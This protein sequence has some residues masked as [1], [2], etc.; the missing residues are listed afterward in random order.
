MDSTN[1]ISILGN[2]DVTFLLLKTYLSVDV[3]QQ[4]DIDDLLIDK[5]GVENINDLQPDYVYSLALKNLPEPHLNDLNILAAQKTSEALK[6]SMMP[7][8]SMFGNLGTSF[9]NR[10]LYINGVNLY[11]APIGKV[12]VGG[13]NYDVLPLQPFSTFIYGKPGLFKQYSNN[14]RQ[15]IGISINIPIL[16]SALLKTNYEKSKLYTKSLVI[17]KEQANEKLKHD[18]YQAFKI[19]QIAIQ[20]YNASR[21]MVEKAQRIYD[22]AVTK[23]NL[24]MLST[25]EFT[26]NLNNLYKAKMEE[27]VNK[28][29][30]IFKIKVLEFY[31]GEGLKF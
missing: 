3:S 21:K 12:I 16:N 8:I 28:F 5:I 30:Y 15:S 1:L 6:G 31:K 19:A 7:T 29:D 23:Y 14:F 4:L 27:I 25:F 20:Q 24:G 2:I 22:V 17:Q 13:T 9:N 18:I 11:T 26:T 10:A